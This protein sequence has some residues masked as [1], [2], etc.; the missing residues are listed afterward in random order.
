MYAPAVIAIT[1]FKSEILTD[2]SQMNPLDSQK[3]GIPNAVK[4]IPLSCT[5][6]P[7]I[8]A[9]FPALSHA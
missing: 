7:C 5:A 8:F 2:I 4:S 6:F 1:L 9:A 3:P